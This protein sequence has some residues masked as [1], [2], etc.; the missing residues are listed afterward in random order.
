MGRVKGGG[1]LVISLVLPLLPK[2]MGWGA[3][4][5]FSGNPQGAMRARMP[6]EPVSWKA[7]SCL[8]APK[9]GQGVRVRECL[10]VSYLAYVAG[11][12]LHAQVKEVCAVE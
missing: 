11:R 8:L 4:Y 12:S 6:A 3:G 5:S 1:P 2:K 9:W 10:H 7:G